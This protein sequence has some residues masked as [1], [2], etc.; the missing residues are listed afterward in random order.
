[1]FPTFLSGHLK[2]VCLSLDLAWICC[3]R[4][5]ITIKL[6]SRL[7]LSRDAPRRGRLT[8]SECVIVIWYGLALPRS[9]TAAGS[10]CFFPSFLLSPSSRRLFQVFWTGMHPKNTRKESTWVLLLLSQVNMVWQDVHP[11]AAQM[12]FQQSLSDIYWFF[13]LRLAHLFHLWPNLHV[14]KHVVFQMSVDLTTDNG[15]TWAPFTRYRNRVQT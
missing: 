4:A 12:R 10:V 7:P 11:P 6:E 1:M 13:W 5:L 15:A 14:F 8:G 2:N 9:G 3:P